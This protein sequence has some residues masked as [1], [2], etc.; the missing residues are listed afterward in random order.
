MIEFLS[1]FAMYIVIVVLGSYYVNL[2]IT[3]DKFSKEELKAVMPYLSRLRDRIVDEYSLPLFVITVAVSSLL[4]IALTMITEHWALNSAILFVAMYYS[5]PLLK[6][7][8]DKANVTTGGSLYDTAMG[9]FAKYNTI[10]IIG[11]GAGTA[12][13]LMYNWAVNKSVHFLWFFA[14]FILI[15]ILVGIAVHRVANE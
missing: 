1:L 2:Y 13:S 3:Q 10:I 8:I 14:N 4:G 11:F 15:T 12:A 5:F 7:N 9:M 6:K